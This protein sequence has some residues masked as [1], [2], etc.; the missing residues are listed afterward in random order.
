MTTWRRGRDLVA[1]RLRRAEVPMVDTVANLGA[2]VIRV[3]G[4]AVYLFK[5]AEATPPALIANV[6][7]HSV[8][9]EN[10]LLLAVEVSE[11][12]YVDAS[13]RVTVTD[14]GG[15]VLQLRICHGFMQEP[16][17]PAAIAGVEIRGERLDPGAVTYFLG[18]ELV[19]A[20]DIEGMHPWREHLFVFLDRGADSAARFFDLPIDRVVTVGTH[21]EI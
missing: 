9:H 18:D 15:G 20:G 5:D 12:A 2:N 13:Q 21:V 7:H 6:K 3:P 10:V 17:V 4:T 14:L 8:L 19:I 11:Q 1:A 16:D